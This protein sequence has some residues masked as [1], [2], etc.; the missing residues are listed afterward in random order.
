M[1]TSKSRIQ[2]YLLIN[3][4]DSFASQIEEWIS[5]VEK[6]ID[7]YCGT[8]FEG[9]TEARYFDGDGTSEILID[10]LVSLT[11]IEILD[12]DGSVEYTLDAVTDYYLYPAN[13]TPKNR[14]IINRFNAD[15]PRFPK[16]YPQNVKITGE[17]GY[18]SSVPK[19]IQFVA[20]RLVAGIIGEGGYD[21]GK[22]IKSERLGEYAITYQE[23]KELAEKFKIFEILDRHRRLEV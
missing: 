5:V 9:T 11:K 1:Y 14:I 4:D 23:V 2:N 12:D 8:S 6:F 20:T 22:E 7:D 17:W 19:D 18:S 15:V 3:I 10:D 13:K 16:T 21:I